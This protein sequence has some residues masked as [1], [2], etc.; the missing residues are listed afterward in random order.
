MIK[1]IFFPFT[2]LQATD[3]EALSALFKSISFFPASKPD[4]FEQSYS[5]IKDK[6]FLLPIY[7]ENK[8]FKLV[9][10]KV[11]E[12]RNWGELNKENK[13]NL[14]AFLQNRPYFTDNTNV[15]HIRDVIE[16][17]HKENNNLQFKEESL[18]KNLMF[19]RLAKIHDTEKENLN[20]KF[21]T[22][23]KNEQKLFSDI[24]GID[25]KFDGKGAGDLGEY[26]TSKRVSAWVEFFNN[27][28]PFNPSL[29]F[30]TTSFAVME[31][32]L[33]V[34]KN[35]IK[36]LDIDN[37]KVHE[38]KCKNKNQWVEIFNKYVENLVIPDKQLL[39]VPAERDDNCTLEVKIKLY[40]L[41]G[42]DI[43]SFFQGVGEKI[44]VCLVSV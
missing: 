17:P 19:L 25:P 8:D 2:H 15:R 20:N 4:E 22:I 35:K 16:H 11:N 26:M 9:L 1:P 38:K 24:Q 7:A 6:N 31:Y 44:P 42:D 13:G 30:V 34:S 23:E 5:H 3:I 10:N 39:N 29:L 36:L 12:Y 21:N 32:L 37:L 27:K 28:N 40:L 14:K 33:S 43:S 41:Q 18:L